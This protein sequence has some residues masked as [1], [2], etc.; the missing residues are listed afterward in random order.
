MNT[1]MKKKIAFVVKRYGK[2][3]NGGAEYQCRTLAEHLKEYYDVEILTSC[4][5]KYGP[6]DNFYNAGEEE[7]DGIKVRRFPVEYIRNKQ[8]YTELTEKIKKEDKSAEEE[9]IMEEG[10]YCP[11]FIPYMKEHGEQYAA[12]IFITYTG[13]LTVM[14]M[15]LGLKNVILVPTAHDESK[16][17]FP[18]YKVAFKRTDAILYNSIEERDLVVGRFEV[19]KTKSRL[20]CI[21]IDIPEQ[22]EYEMPETLKKYK[23]NYI[24]YVGRIS[25]TKN[26]QELNR[27]FIEYKKRNPS[28]LKMIIVGRMDNGM[29]IT[30]S[31]DIVYAGFVTE[32]EKTAIIQNARLLVMPS[33]YESLSL[34]ILESM[35]VKRPVLVNGRCEVLK[36]Q[37]IRSN[38]GLYYENYF[39]FEAALNYI[40]SNEDAYAQMCENG[41]SFV[42]NNYEWE[43]VIKNIVSLIEEVIE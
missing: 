5:R 26:F 35:A 16:L 8:R 39:E 30:Y 29:R 7:I 21:G 3:V 28:D 1:H 20:T 13:Y 31:E 4:A 6:W 11:Q 10:P 19:G 22:K 36:G 14:G 32:E 9:W 25:K 17:Y 15:K 33:L 34:V 37:C 23:G 12:I 38:A 27:D 43:S 40:L 41:F 18:I 42:K 2:E 24:V